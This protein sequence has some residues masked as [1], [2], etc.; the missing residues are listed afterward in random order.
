[1]Y[2]VYVLPPISDAPSVEGLQVTF[3]TSSRP[4]Q[5][6][7]EDFEGFNWGCIGLY[8]YIDGAKGQY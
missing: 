5:P 4:D 8:V 7:M 1:M 2:P 6:N 3:T